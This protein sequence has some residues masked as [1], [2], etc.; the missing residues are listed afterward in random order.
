MLTGKGEDVR[1]QLRTAGGVVGQ[2][3]ECFRH[4]QTQR[5]R[6]GHHGHFHHRRVFDQRALQFER[7]DAVV[8][9]L[10][11]IIG[12]ANKSD[13]AVAVDLRGIAGAVIDR[14]ASLRRFFPGCLRSTASGQADVPP[15]EGHFAFA[16][17]QAVGVE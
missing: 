17:G 7:A 2:D 16:G 9:G 13:V 12:T 8:G 4:R 15:G 3:Q 14:R 5:I 10:E 6:A 11:H 1:G